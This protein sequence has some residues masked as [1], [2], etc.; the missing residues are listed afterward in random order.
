MAKQAVTQTNE[1]R[2]PKS[3]ASQDSDYGRYDFFKLAPAMGGLALILMVAS[4]ALIFIKGF[5]YGI[6]F[7]GGTEIQVKFEQPVDAGD[8]RSVLSNTG[9]KDPMV[10]AFESGSEFLIR[11]ETPQGAN[12]KETNELNNANVAKVQEALQ[13]QFGLTD[14]GVLRVDTV[15]PQVGAE[16][17][18]NGLLATFYSLLVILIYIGLRFD[19]KYAPGA[20]ICLVHD[21]LLTMGVF[22]LLGREVNVQ[23]MAAILTLIGYSLNDT[24]VTFDRIRETLPLNREKGFKFVINK[25]IND[26]LGRT[27]LT[28]GTTLLAVIALYIFGTGVIEDLAFT[29]AI[30]VVVGTFSSIYIA[31]PLVLV[32]DK[33]QNRK[34]A[35]KA[36]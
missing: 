33:F 36:A 35:K 31:A 22:A 5:N 8:L 7:S 26:M 23:I 24:I 6:D 30:G 20:V 13:A 28:A 3:A 1:S 17:K 2:A 34:M 21:A 18:K 16:L 12:D 19:Y 25:A 27:I 29:L 14:D 11:L 4:L 32:V 9:L 15:G 10:Q